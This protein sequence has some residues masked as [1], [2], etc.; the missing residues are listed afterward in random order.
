MVWISV[1]SLQF[2]LLYLYGWLGLLEYSSICSFVRV[3]QLFK[4]NPGATRCVGAGGRNGLKAINHLILN[5]ISLTHCLT[6]CKLL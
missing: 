5:L 6:L 3:G 2:C 4:C 1:I